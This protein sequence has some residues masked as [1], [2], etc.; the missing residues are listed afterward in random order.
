MGTIII[1]ASNFCKV[2]LNI[3]RKCSCN[4][5]PLGSGEIPSMGLL[6]LGSL[7]CSS[8]RNGAQNQ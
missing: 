4:C 5:I 6:T 1:N 8:Y 3:F 7:T 2:F